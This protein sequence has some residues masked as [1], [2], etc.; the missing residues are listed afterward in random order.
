M[1]ITF[2]IETGPLPASVLIERFNPTFEAAKNIKDPDKIA[3]DIAAKKAEWL[4]KSAL[5]AERG[6]ILAIGYKVN[7]QPIEIIEGEE[8]GLLIAWLSVMN[9][10]KSHVFHGFNILDFDLPFI[11]RRCVINGIRFPFYD[12][13]DKWKPWKVATYDAMKDWCFGNYR[14]FVSLN[15]VARAL[16]VGVK[17]GSGDMFHELYKTDKEKARDYLRNDVQLTYDVCERLTL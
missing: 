4:D 13:G 5:H 11:R 17:N 9:N 10:R 14:E 15:T 1:K 12:S 8:P 7:D 3:A 16:G 6:E 2:D